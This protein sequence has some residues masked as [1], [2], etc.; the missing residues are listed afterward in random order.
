ML[1][2]ACEREL[3]DCQSGTCG[4]AIC[5]HVQGYGDVEGRFGVISD[6][7]EIALRVKKR[8]AFSY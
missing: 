6:P 1:T 7:K 8:L 2:H 4:G 5:F 3:F